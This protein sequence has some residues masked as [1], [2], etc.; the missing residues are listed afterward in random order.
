VYRTAIR[1]TFWLALVG[2]LTAADLFTALSMTWCIGTC[3]FLAYL[4]VRKAARA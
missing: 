1:I 3:V 2:L 4:D